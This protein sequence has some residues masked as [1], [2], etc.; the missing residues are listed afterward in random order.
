MYDNKGFAKKQPIEFV[1][2]KFVDCCLRVSPYPILLIPFNLGFKGD[3]FF[4]T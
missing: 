4:H 2:S 3:D 1:P